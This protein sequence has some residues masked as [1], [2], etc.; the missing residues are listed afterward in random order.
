MEG[1]VPTMKKFLPFLEEL[2]RKLTVSAYVFI[3]SFVTGFFLS[4]PTLKYFVAFFNIS[5]VTIAATSPFQ[6]ANIAVDIGF[7]FASFVTLP[8]LIYQVF[9]FI[10][11]GLTKKERS[12]LLLSIPICVGLF[13]IGFSYGFLILYY[14]FDLL[15]K[16]NERIGIK[17]IWDIG[18]YLSQL[19]TTSSFLGILFQ[20]PLVLTLLVRIGVCS[21]AMLRQKRRIAIF[22]VFIIV[23]LLPP[24]DG[25]SLIAMSL[26]LVALYEVTILVNNRKK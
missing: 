17:N 10:F 15:A 8:I 13:V 1:F 22:I 24:T 7:F 16:I 23:S 25:L 5:G 14:S 9:N 19:F 26:P 18:L 6:F 4:V 3:V 20:F 12:L 2:R 21:S 11:P